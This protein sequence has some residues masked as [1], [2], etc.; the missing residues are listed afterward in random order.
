M[1]R[2]GNGE[3]EREGVIW[4]VRW[5]ADGVHRKSW[6]I[7]SS[8]R[9]SSDTHHEGFYLIHLNSAIHYGRLSKTTIARAVVDVVRPPQD[10]QWPPLNGDHSGRPEETIN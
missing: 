1:A 3:S 9:V 5:P 10:E 4:R 7:P 6:T 2:N 8:S